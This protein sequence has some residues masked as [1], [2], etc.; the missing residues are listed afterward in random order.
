M[1]SCFVSPLCVLHHVRHVPTLVAVQELSALLHFVA[2]LPW[3]H[4]SHLSVCPLVVRLPCPCSMCD[5]AALDSA[6]AVN[7]VGAVIRDVW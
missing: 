6:E 7:A 4:I 5:P 1:R 2:A 3:S